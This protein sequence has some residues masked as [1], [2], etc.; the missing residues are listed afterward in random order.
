MYETDGNFIR[1]LCE[2]VKYCVNSVGYKLTIGSWRLK[3]E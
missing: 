1:F 2:Y 3:M